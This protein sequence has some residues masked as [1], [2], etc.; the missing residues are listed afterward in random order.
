M[1]ETTTR[2]H[3]ID[4]LFM[5]GARFLRAVERDALVWLTVDARR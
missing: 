1:S 2:L 4:W 3:A 5:I